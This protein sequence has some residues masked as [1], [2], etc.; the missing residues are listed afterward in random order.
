MNMG[1][2]CQLQKCGQ[3][4]SKRDLMEFSWEFTAQEAQNR[5]GAAKIGMG[6]IFHLMQHH[7][8]DIVRCV[9]FL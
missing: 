5:S 7:F 2:E 3:F 4:L 9:A 6:L 8:A 1:L